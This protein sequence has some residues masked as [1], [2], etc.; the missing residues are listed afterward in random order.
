MN[1]EQIAKK[2]QINPNTLNAK[3]DGIKI[4]IKS[5]QEIV[6]EMERKNVDIQVVSKVK[7]LGEF[8][9]DVSI[10]SIS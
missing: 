6:S 4:A 1:L 3:D 10:S 9:N 7:T 5:V 2:Y 8:L